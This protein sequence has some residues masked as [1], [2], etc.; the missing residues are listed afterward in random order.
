MSSRD[1]CQCLISDTGAIGQRPLTEHRRR[2]LN[3]LHS[4]CQHFAALSDGTGRRDINSLKVILMVL[5]SVIK[6][7]A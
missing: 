3:S 4:Q 1:S 6:Q 2:I 5:N 7:A